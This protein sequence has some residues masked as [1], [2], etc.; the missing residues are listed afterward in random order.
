MNHMT[1]ILPLVVLES[2]QLQFE[3]NSLAINAILN[4]SIQK[5]FQHVLNAILNFVR[6]N[7]WNVGFSTVGQ[8]L[9]TLQVHGNHLDDPGL[10]G[11]F[12]LLEEQAQKIDQGY[13]SIDL[14]R[15]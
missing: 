14:G 4:E 8:M 12:R 7:Q 10:L 11:R 6:I 5:R 3:W 1:K 13:T 15:L 9:R 2:Q